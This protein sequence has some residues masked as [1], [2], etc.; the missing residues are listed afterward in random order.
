MQSVSHIAAQLVLTAAQGANLW[1]PL[2]PQKHQP[3]A[4]LILATLQGTIG[5]LNHYFN[6]DG[7]PAQAAWEPPKKT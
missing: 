3:L 1:T 2:I 5:I 4:A 6:P 7:T